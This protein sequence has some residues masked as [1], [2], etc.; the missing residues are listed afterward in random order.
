MVDQVADTVVAISDEQT[1]DRFDEQFMLLRPRLVRICAGFAGRDL[2]EDIVH[3]TYEKGRRMYRQLRDVDAF[4]AWLT[5]IAI[6]LCKDAQRRQNLARARLPLLARRERSTQ[7]SDVALTE[8]VERLSPRDRTILVLHHGH[9]YG[10]HEIAQLLDM[11]HSNVR[12]VI[13]RTR[14]RLARQWLEDR[15]HE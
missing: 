1:G 10:L 8:L 3:D 2:A 4:D 5:R 6:N 11:S 7:Q 14:H 15:S 12:S 9:G 13:A